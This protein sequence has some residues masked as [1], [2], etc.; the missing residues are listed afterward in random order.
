[1]IEKSSEGIPN[2]DVISEHRDK[3]EKGKM[4][5]SKGYYKSRLDRIKNSLE[6]R[7]FEPEV[8]DRYKND[9]CYSCE[10]SSIIGLGLQ[11][12]VWGV[13]ANGSRCI[14]VILSHI[15]HIDSKEQKYWRALE[16]NKKESEQARVESR[17]HRPLVQG[18]PLNVWT[19]FS[20]I[21][22][23]LKFINQITSPDF[24]FR[25][26]PSD[27]PSFLQPITKNSKKEYLDYILELDKLLSTNIMVDSFF[28]KIK[29]AQ[30]NTMRGKGQILN[31]LSIWLEELGINKNDID[32]CLKALKTV[33]RQRKEKAHKLFKDSSGDYISE[34][35]Q[36]TLEVWESLYTIAHWLKPI[37][38]AN[39]SVREPAVFSLCKII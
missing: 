25:E 1:L 29:N 34:Q 26:V 9:P 37:L 21:L 15:S 17:Y 23:T 6:W 28:K 27:T 36:I 14:A 30:K 19:S 16:L 20:V 32:R 24:L 7:F 10:S 13:K 38:D 8:L 39:D 3:N 11:Q 12:Y 18:K 2:S 35:R 31:L 4:G 5:K 22:P 33:R